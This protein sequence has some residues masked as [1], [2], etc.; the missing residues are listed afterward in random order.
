[1]LCLTQNAT[2]CIKKRVIFIIMLQIQL[3]LAVLLPGWACFLHVQYNLFRIC[4]AREAAQTLSSQWSASD[5]A[6]LQLEGII[7]SKSSTTSTLTTNS[8]WNKGDPLNSAPL[9]SGGYKVLALIINI[10]TTKKK[11]NRE[12]ETWTNSPWWNTP[13]MCSCTIYHEPK[14]ICT[15]KL[16][17][18][19]RTPTPDK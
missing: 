1:M 12:K 7:S 18:W 4:A 5:Y 3:W 2:G 13:Q 8:S 17:Y 10:L 9:N 16:I 14:L 6:W 11:R 15:V 19:T